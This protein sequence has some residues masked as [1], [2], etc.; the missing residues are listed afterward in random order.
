MP[1]ALSTDPEPYTFYFDAESDY[2]QIYVGWSYPPTSWKKWGELIYV[3]LRCE[4][5]VIL[6]D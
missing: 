6:E 2:N 3:G 4:C 5:R 1:K